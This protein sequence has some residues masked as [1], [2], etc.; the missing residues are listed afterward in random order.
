MYRW[1]VSARYHVDGIFCFSCACFVFV[2][3]EIGPEFMCWFM[4]YVNIEWSK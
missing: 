3:C 2:F 1:T 4:C